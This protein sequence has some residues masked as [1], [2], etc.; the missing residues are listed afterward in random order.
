[1]TNARDTRYD[2]SPPTQHPRVRGRCPSCGSESLFLGTNGYV[3]CSVIGCKDPGAPTDILAAGPPALDAAEQRGQQSEIDCPVC[4]ETVKQVA[5]AT[6][7]LALWQHWN[8]A[9]PKRAEHRGT[10]RGTTAECRWV[11]EQPEDDP[12]CD[13]DAALHLESGHR[14]TCAA[15][16]RSTAAQQ[17][18][19]CAEAAWGLKEQ[20]DELLAA[21]KAAAEGAGGRVNG[22]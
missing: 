13:C 22:D 1:M 2:N 8:W 14:P 18:R 11:N 9:C 19:E 5:S 3:T 17:L 7:S 16:V 21:L 10:A 4:G 20:R 12:L 6:L 15:V